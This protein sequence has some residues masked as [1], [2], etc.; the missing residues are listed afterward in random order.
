MSAAPAAARS[1][2]SYKVSID[3]TEFTQPQNDGVESIVVEDHV[4]MVETLSMRLNGAEGSPT[5]NAEIGKVV[6]VKMGS[7]SAL[8]FKGEIT[9]LEPS[10]SSD[11]M[12]TITLRALDHAHRLARGRVTRFFEKK[13]DSEI[14]TTVGG[15][16][17]LSVTVDATTEQHAYTLQRNESNL[18][19]LKRLA[20]RNNYQLA[21]DDG[22]LI[23]KKANFSSASTTITMGSNLRSLR[24]NFN[25]MDQVT[26]VIVRGWD[27]R[28]KKEIVG[29]ASVG[30]IQSIGGGTVGASLAQTKFGEHT[31]YITDVPV[32]SQAAATEV[33]KAELNRLA[34]Q[35]ARG[36]CTV[37]GNDALRAGTVVEFSGLSQPHNGKYYIISSR[38][39]VTAH[40]GYLTEITFCGN[41]LGT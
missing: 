35:F 33:A 25:S 28:E 30:D 18:A 37:D 38:H 21:V 4:D 39:T 23:F 9:A 16:S 41:T 22:K 19:F 8:L 32:S 34:R 31:A 11:G 6:T 7:G 24:M 12:C 29:T 14:A 10:W 20:A 17:G 13:K 1:A 2:T 26:K 15:E 27:I 3:G 36:S 5:W 40:A